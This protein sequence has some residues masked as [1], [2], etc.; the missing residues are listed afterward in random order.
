MG[1]RRYQFTAAAVYQPLAMDQD[2]IGKADQIAR[3]GNA[4]ANSVALRPYQMVAGCFEKMTQELS[5]G[6]P[7]LIRNVAPLRMNSDQRSHEFI[8]D[9]F[10]FVR[11]INEG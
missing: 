2:K 7:P 6:Q 10:G 4:S 3:N 5:A 11:T 8:S 1:G 9:E